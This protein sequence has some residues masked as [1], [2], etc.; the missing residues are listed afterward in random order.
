MS[1]ITTLILLVV[2]F[3]YIIVGGLVFDVL[4]AGNEDATLAK[5]YDV[6]RQFLGQLHAVSY[7]DVKKRFLRF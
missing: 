3:V 6:L 5:S 2:V 1:W 7:I 4:E